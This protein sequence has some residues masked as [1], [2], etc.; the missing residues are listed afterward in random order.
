MLAIL[1]VVTA[2]V[3]PQ[4]IGARFGNEAVPMAG[5]S[6]MVM[7]RDARR[8]AIQYN[9]TVTVHLDPTSGLYEVDTTGASGTGLYISRQ[10]GMGG[11]ESLQSPLQRLQYVFRPTGAA[12]GDSV[13][14]QGN[15]AAMIMVDPWS[16]QPTAYYR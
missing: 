15:G 16:G 1:A 6:L 12:F 10:L 14:A 8:M 9:Q 7:L 3:I 11:F 4:F 13:I 5:D 2:L